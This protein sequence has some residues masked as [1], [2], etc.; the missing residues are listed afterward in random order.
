MG[1]L[2]LIAGELDMDGHFETIADYP[3]FA[4]NQEAGGYELL[5]P[6]HPPTRS[7]CTW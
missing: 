3:L 2:K 6:R 5:L 4:E 7:C 1:D